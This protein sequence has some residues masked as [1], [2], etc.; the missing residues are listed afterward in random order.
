MFSISTRAVGAVLAAAAV[1]GAMALAAPA[2]AAV[3]GPDDAPDANV[4]CGTTF[5]TWTRRRG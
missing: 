1:T 4:P 2:Q 5:R 3:S